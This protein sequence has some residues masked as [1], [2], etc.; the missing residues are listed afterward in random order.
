MLVSNIDI[1]SGP[2]SRCLEKIFETRENR[3]KSDFL[4]TFERTQQSMIAFRWLVLAGTLLVEFSAKDWVESRRFYTYL[5]LLWIW[6]SRVSSG[7]KRKFL[8]DLLKGDLRFC[9]DG[10]WIHSIHDRSH[11]ACAESTSRCW[12]SRMLTVFEVSCRSRSDTAL[13]VPQRYMVSAYACTREGSVKKYIS[14][15]P[16]GFSEVLCNRAYYLLFWMMD[17]ACLPK[18]VGTVSY[19]SNIFIFFAV[20][21]QRELEKCNDFL[22]RCSFKRSQYSA[23]WRRVWR[24]FRSFISRTYFYTH[25]WSYRIAFICR[26]SSIKEAL[27][28]NLA[29][30]SVMWILLRGRTHKEDTTKMGQFIH[31]L[32]CLSQSARPSNFL[33][34]QLS[35]TR[36]YWD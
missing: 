4:L 6:T 2:P 9:Y 32:L 25:Y 34:A 35:K 23:M 17:D 12:R 20:Y 1:S 31:R 13:F 8:S 3:G 18:T 29:K 5:S 16:G 30:N 36:R 22:C 11:Y 10:I 7:I 19:T 26:G 28:S 15:E 14:S 33:W 21:R 27:S 24:S